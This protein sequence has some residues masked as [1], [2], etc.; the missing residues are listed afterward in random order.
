MVETDLDKGIRE[1]SSG[2]VRFSIK[3]DD[4]EEN[5]KVHDAF[6]EFC[7]IECDNNYTLG[8]R[9]LLEYIE[10]D[11]KFASMHLNIEYLASRL[12]EIESKLDKPK[13]EEKKDTEMF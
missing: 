3:A 5:Q 9:K 12:A 13:E 1:I 7:K 2:F 11:S 8:L 4:T 10:E 6:K